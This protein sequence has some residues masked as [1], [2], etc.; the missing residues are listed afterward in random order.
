MLINNIFKFCFQGSQVSLASL[1]LSTGFATSS[2]HPILAAEKQ[3]TA[4]TATPIVATKPTLYNAAATGKQQ[5]HNGIYIFGQSSK[6]EQIGKEYLVFESRNGKVIGAFYMP[7][8]EYSCFYGT[9]DRGEMDLN[10]VDPDDQSTYFHSIA[11]QSSSLVASN[12]QIA[13][14]GYQPVSGVSNNARQLLSSCRNKYQ[15]QVWNH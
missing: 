10:V 1:L 4:P 15:Q 12:E 7:A 11:L 2:F 13:L 8:S 6:P 3:A 14:Q 5:V 9:L